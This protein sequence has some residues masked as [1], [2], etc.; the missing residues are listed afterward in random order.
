MRGFNGVDGLT[1]ALGETH[2][3]TCVFDDSVISESAYSLDKFRVELHIEST[4]SVGNDLM[5]AV[6]YDGQV[7]SGITVYFYMEILQC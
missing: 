1:F 2:G 6:I 7:T 3:A 5:S 4:D